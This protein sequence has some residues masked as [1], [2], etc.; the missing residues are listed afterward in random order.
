MKPPIFR[1]SDRGKLEISIHALS[2]MLAF[3]QNA[4]PKREAGGVLLGRYIRES[5]DIV[6]DEVTVPMIGDRRRRYSF[7]RDRQR[8]Q[9]AIDQ[10]W[11]ET[12]GT[13]TYLGEWHTHPEDIPIPSDTDVK[14]WKCRL[15]ED[16]FSG[17]ALYFIII[18]I[19]NLRIWEGSKSSLSYELI[20]E[21]CHL[22]ECNVEDEY[23]Q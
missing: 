19:E 5:P 17:N 14:N 3:V 21:L 11:Q 6:I 10:A 2:L 15:K 9:K 8:H 12:E 16:I 22:E 23:S 13:S 18:G 1:K 7:Y 4:R 20:G